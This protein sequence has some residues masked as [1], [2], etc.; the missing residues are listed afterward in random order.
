VRSPVSRI[1]DKK[2]TIAVWVGLMGESAIA[3]RSKWG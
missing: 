2:S 1:K 3:C